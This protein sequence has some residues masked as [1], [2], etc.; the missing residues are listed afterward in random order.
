MDGFSRR[1]LTSMSVKELRVTCTLVHLHLLTVRFLKVSSQ[2]V[3]EKKNTNFTFC[4]IRHLNL[5]THSSIISHCCNCI[6][7]VPITSE[8]EA[9]QYPDNPKL[10][11]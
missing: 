4:I 5:H 9:T 8:G 10:G 11:S 1:R 3:F 2:G 6:F 7:K